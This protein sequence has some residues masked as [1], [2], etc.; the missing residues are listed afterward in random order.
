MP[1][2]SRQ[3]LS[4]ELSALNR[5]TNNLMRKIAEQINDIRVMAGPEEM[6]I[7]RDMVRLEQGNLT[8][9]ELISIM[10]RADDFMKVAIVKAPPSERTR[11]E[12]I[13][14]DPE[15]VMLIDWI[16][17]MARQVLDRRAA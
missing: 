2:S 1:T 17:V 11:L 10:I 12:A 15:F 9:E 14:D 16:R 8:L 4:R 7:V 5:R 13:Y 3:Q 6:A